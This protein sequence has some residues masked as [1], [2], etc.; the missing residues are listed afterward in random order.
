MGDSFGTIGASTLGSSVSI[1]NFVRV[2]GGDLSVESE[3][4]LGGAELSVTGL[5]S[6]AAACLSIQVRF[7]RQWCFSRLQADSRS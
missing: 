7:L 3:N 2:T 6:F 4:L 5:A 1:G